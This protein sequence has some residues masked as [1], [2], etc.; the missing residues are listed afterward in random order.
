M[1]ALV[2]SVKHVNGR[3]LEGTEGL[4]ICP[5]K[6]RMRVANLFFAFPWMPSLLTG[7]NLEVRYSRTATLRPEEYLE[8][9]PPFLFRINPQR[10][11]ATG[12]HHTSILSIPSHSPVMALDTLPATGTVPR[13][14]AEG[15]AAI[16]DQLFE[17]CIPLHTLSVSL[18]RE[19][20]FGSYDD[21]ICS[22]GLQLTELAESNSTGDKEW[23]ESILGAHPRLGQSKIEST[24]SR[25]EQA[26]LNSG[27]GS[28]DQSLSQLNNLYEQTFP[29]LRY[30][31]FVDGRDRSTIM[32]DMRT[33]IERRD[34]VAERNAAIKVCTHG[35][36]Q[37]DV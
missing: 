4:G 14:S 2:D 31:V 30:I 21:L 7:Q 34:A 25:A 17:P 22:V 1:S 35:P 13:L 15:R 8:A 36:A 16:L 29:G 27:N 20:T 18:L 37:N 3:D 24:Q 12:S 9:P 23:L 33:R 5:L 6:R 26:Q 10:S 32:E 28:S 19:K 11:T